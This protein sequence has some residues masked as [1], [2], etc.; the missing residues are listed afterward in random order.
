MGAGASKPEDLAAIAQA[1][2]NYKPPL[3]PPNPDNP[4]VFF[5]IK[6]GRYGDATPL[7]RIEIELKADVAPK[8]AENF[9]Q[10]ALKEEGQGYK[11]SRFH[12]VITGFMCQGGDYERD[13]GTGGSSIYGAKF[14]DENFVLKHLGEGVLSM[15]NAGP[16][17]NGSQ[18]FLC[19]ASTPW[20][21]GKHVVFGQ[22]ISG[23]NV[24][25]AVE[26]CGSRDGSTAF[27]VMIGNSGLVSPGK[28]ATTA[29]LQLHQ[30]PG[31]APR[32]IKTSAAASAPSALN[33]LKQQRRTVLQGRQVAPARRPQAAMRAA[34]AA[35]VRSVCR[36]L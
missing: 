5:D 16:N 11:G 15:A 7:G 2:I 35:P 28:A 23:Y 10:L 31:A 22:V 4:V 27:D 9:K 1:P 18:F 12:R 29:S 33:Q 17:T 30:Q 3:G 36:A 26:A 20:L 32:R 25:K 14:A 24:V 8:T 34:A 6:L 21:D 19:V 13:N